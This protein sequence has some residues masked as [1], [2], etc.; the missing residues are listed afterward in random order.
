MTATAVKGW[1]WVEARPRGWWQ[2]TNTETGLFDPNSGRYTTPVN[3]R[4][5]CTHSLMPPGDPCS[6]CGLARVPFPDTQEHT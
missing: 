3:H 5:G 1:A 2:R 6:W 4:V